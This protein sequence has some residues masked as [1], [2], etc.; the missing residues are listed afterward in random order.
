MDEETVLDFNFVLRQRSWIRKAEYGASLLK[1][2]ISMILRFRM[3]LINSASHL[4]IRF[5]FN[6][7]RLRSIR[8]V[9]RCLLLSAKTCGTNS[10]SLRRFKFEVMQTQTQLD[11]N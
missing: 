2:Q 8:R 1:I 7:T 9:K 3:T 10:F 6:R 4:A 11:T 5:Y